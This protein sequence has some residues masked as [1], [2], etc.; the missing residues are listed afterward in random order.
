MSFSTIWIQIQYMQHLQDCR[1]SSNLIMFPVMLLIFIKDCVDIH[2][3][4]TLKV[5]LHYIHTFMHGASCLGVCKIIQTMLMCLCIC[6]IPSLRPACFL[7]IQGIRWGYKGNTKTFKTEK[8]T[9]HTKPQSTD[10]EID[11]YN[12]VRREKRYITYSEFSV[13]A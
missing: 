7:I 5:T 13:N 10:T 4:V 8:F 3:A 12:I 6:L 11:V 2:P 1:I 9:S